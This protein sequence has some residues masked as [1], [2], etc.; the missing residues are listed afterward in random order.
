MTNELRSFTARL[1]V[2]VTDA[3]MAKSKKV[4]KPK[5]G[6]DFYRAFNGTNG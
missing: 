4:E 6:S 2:E 3:L 5:T 1:D